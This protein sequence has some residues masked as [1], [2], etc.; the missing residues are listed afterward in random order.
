MHG[1]K[2]NIRTINLIPLLCTEAVIGN[3]IIIII[4]EKRLP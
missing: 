1:A 4:G 2:I 3:I